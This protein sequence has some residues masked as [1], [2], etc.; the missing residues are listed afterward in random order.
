[1][2][3]KT[4]ISILLSVIIFTGRP[5]PRATLT[6]ARGVH[7]R[8]YGY[9]YWYHLVQNSYGYSENHDSTPFFYYFY[10]SPL[11]TL[12]HTIAKGSTFSISSPFDVAKLQKKN[13]DVSSTG[14]FPF[15]MS[16]DTHNHIPYHPYCNGDST[17]L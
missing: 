17:L 12:A 4:M 1:M 5:I 13:L 11:S 9:N 10:M 16:M 14:S 6:G 7:K 2:F 3:P 15:L 8:L